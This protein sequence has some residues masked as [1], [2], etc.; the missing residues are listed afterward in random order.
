MSIVKDKGIKYEI[1]TMNQIDKITHVKF[2][3]GNVVDAWGTSNAY[4]RETEHGIKFIDVMHEDASCDVLMYNEL[5]GVQLLRI[6]EG[7]D[8]SI[9]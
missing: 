1:L 3:E 2:L 4:C 8:V 5:E 7:E 6:I 9:K